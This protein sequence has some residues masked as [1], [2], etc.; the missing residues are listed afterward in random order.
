MT[1]D[2]N[3]PT[4]RLFTFWS[5]GWVLVLAVIVSGLVTW[6]TLRLLGQHRRVTFGDG[7]NIETYRF[8]LSP[9]LLPEGAIVASGTP[10]NGIAA[11][12]DPKFFTRTE[13]EHHPDRK[14]RKLLVSADRVIGVAI[15]GEARAYPLRILNWHE[16]VND[17]VGG[18]PIAVTFHPLCDSVAVFDRRV[19]A[20]TVEFR[21]SGLLYNSNQLIFPHREEPGGESLYCQLLAKAVTGP[22]AEAGKTLTVLPSKIVSWGAWKKE[23]PDTVVLEPDPVYRKQYSRRPYN[24]YRGT[25]SLR[26]P[27]DPYPPEGEWKPWSRVLAVLEPDTGPR[28]IHDYE[29]T[30]PDT[31]EAGVIHAYWWSWAAIR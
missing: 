12:S 1:A 6:Q 25:Q 7:K 31:G 13:I 21:V 16:V 20:D 24:N 5:A 8:A 26:Y 11:M 14:T 17:T 15:G 9:S 18:V 27:V 28:L 22:D 23:H 2:D 30:P 19:G 3:R 29:G 4:G 10:R